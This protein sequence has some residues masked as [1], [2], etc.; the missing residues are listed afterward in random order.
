MI[1]LTRIAKW[2][3]W[4]IV[5]YTLLLLTLVYT[6]Y[7]LLAIQKNKL[8]ENSRLRQK[9]FILREPSTSLKFRRAWQS[10]LEHL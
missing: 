8:E 6:F 4:N 5:L 9:A 3:I 2:L 10:R 7:Q 1:T